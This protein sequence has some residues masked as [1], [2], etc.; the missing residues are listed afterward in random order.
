[1]V[2][3]EWNKRTLVVVVIVDQFVENFN[4]SLLW[5]FGRLVVSLFVPG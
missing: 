1:M 2:V 5:L 4:A 3:L